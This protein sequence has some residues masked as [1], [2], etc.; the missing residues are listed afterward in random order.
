MF[1]NPRNV[2][3]YRTFSQKLQAFL[4][5]YFKLKSK[6]EHSTAIMIP[7]SHGQTDS[8]HFMLKHRKAADTGLPASFYAETPESPVFAACMHDADFGS[9]D[10]WYG[11]RR[12]IDG[13]L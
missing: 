11:K 12:F 5:I 10:P 4:F 6:N 1:K 3:H 2:V 13:F 9:A 7:E 8:T